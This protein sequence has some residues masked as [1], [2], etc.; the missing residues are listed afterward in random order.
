MDD[1]PEPHMMPR[2]QRPIRGTGIVL[3]CSLV[4]GCAVFALGLAW[5][6]AA[7][8]PACVR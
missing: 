5:A 4:V 1:F 7:I 6:V 8:A 3:A 2:E